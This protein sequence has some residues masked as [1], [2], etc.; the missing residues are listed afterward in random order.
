M[1]NN[2]PDL[3]QQIKFSTIMTVGK[4]IRGLNILIK[5]REEIV[6][7]LEDLSRGWPNDTALNTVKALVYFL[8]EEVKTLRMF[9]KE[10]E[11]SKPK[12]KEQ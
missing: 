8:S 10:L 4:V 1:Q 5:N 7:G 11:S 12:K 9:V 3:F 2:L 6:T